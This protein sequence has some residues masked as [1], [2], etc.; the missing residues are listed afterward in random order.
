MNKDIEDLLVDFFERFAK[1]SNTAKE[2]LNTPASQSEFFYHWL[3]LKGYEIKPIQ[4]DKQ[5]EL[6]WNGGD[7]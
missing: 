7:A 4:R 1:V 6:F 3:W 5:F 2:V